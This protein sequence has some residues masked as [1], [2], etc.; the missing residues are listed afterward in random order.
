MGMSSSS[1]LFIDLLDGLGQLALSMAKDAAKNRAFNK[2][3]RIG[4]TRRPGIDTPLWNALAARVRIHLKKR[5]AKTN[6][7][8]IL[9]VPRQR[10]HEY[11]VA[12]SQAPDAE[13]TLQLL[14][15]LIDREQPGAIPNKPVATQ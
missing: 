5:G 11:F 2:R 10:V 6:L 13:R 14:F 7:G 12:G 4:L 15:W 8:R 1:R 9:G 3:R